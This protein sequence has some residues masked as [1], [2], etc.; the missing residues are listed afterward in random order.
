MSESNVIM[1]EVELHEKSDM[2]PNA[3]ESQEGADEF[4]LP[5]MISTMS[6]HFKG[7]KRLSERVVMT[8]SNLNYSTLVKG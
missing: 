2:L 6:E 7:S 1:K 3:L 8:W 5:A 4:Q